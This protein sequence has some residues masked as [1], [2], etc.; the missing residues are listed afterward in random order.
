MYNL[1]LAWDT[2][3]FYTA[4]AQDLENKHESLMEYFHNF[5]KSDLNPSQTKK[6]GLEIK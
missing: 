4:K 3:D 1:E 2:Y 6:V 5:L